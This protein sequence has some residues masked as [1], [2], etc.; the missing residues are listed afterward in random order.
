MEAAMPYFMVFSDA[1]T[2]QLGWCPKPKFP[3]SLLMN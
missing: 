2:G 1:E 3:I